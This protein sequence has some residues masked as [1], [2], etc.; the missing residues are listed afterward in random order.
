MSKYVIGT[1]G[2]EQYGEGEHAYYKYKLGNEY[3]V[4]ARTAASAIVAAMLHVGSTNNE[5]WVEHFLNATELDEWES[6]LPSNDPAYAQYLT[7]QL[8]ALD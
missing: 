5:Y 7:A 8:I 6:E 2:L 4:E 1:Q 3:L